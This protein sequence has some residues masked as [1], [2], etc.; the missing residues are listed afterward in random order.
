MSERENPFGDLGDLAKAPSKPKPDPA[1]VDQL[2][3]AHGFPSRQPAKEPEKAQAPVSVLV[4]K[5]EKE[6]LRQKVFRVTAAQDRELGKRLADLDTTM[7]DLVL[8]GINVLLKSKG[9]PPI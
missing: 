2:A 5:P 3:E 8:D 4:A 9:L 6:K 1:V 7:Q